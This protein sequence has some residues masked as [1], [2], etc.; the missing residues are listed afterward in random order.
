MLESVEHVNEAVL[1]DGAS[2]GS[3]VSGR[4]WRVRQLV[5]HVGNSAVLSVGEA[6]GGG[7]SG[8]QWRVLESMEQVAVAALRAHVCQCRW[9]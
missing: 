5:E 2:G 7:V 6:G 9:V 1:P 3:G 8:R 4:Q